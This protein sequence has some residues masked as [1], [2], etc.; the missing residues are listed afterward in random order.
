MVSEVLIW[1]IESILL[2]SVPANQLPF[3]DAVLLSLS[4]NLTSFAIGWFLPV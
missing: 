4:M 2:Y 1:G 3:K